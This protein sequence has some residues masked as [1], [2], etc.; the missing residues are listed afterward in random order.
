MIWLDNVPASINHYYGHRAINKRVMKYVKK[1]GKDF[2]FHLSEK[3]AGV[4]EILQGPLRMHI[5]MQ[6]PTKRKHDID[7]YCKPVLDSLNGIVYE[8][9]S[10]IVDLRVTK[11]YKKD[12]PRTHISIVKIGSPEDEE[13][14]FY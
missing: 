1:E 11:S 13:A 6:F 3:A 12:E 10:Q 14:K 9:D 4:T 2:K 8:D 7:N 5:N